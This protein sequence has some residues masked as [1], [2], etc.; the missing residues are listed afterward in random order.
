MQACGKMLIARIAASDN[1]QPGHRDACKHYQKGQHWVDLFI[2][3]VTIMYSREYI[4]F[5]IPMVSQ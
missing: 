1:R 5:T 4:L 2:Q 3:T